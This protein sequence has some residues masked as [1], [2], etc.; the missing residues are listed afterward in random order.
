MA[1]QQWHIS[2]AR[3]IIA[4]ISISLII[5]AVGI[6]ILNSEHVV[7]GDWSNIFSIIFFALAVLLPL[8]QWLYPL[9]SGKPEP[10]LSSK[11]TLIDAALDPHDSPYEQSTE[12]GRTKIIYKGQKPKRVAIDK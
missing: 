5:V 4:I 6:W 12:N 10:P 3:L 11:V 8:I 9:S 7:R 2:K 1:K